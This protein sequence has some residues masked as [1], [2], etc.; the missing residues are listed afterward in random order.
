MF[1]LFGSN[2]LCHWKIKVITNYEVVRFR[3]VE[4]SRIRLSATCQEDYLDMRDGGCMSAWW[5]LH[6]DRLSLYS[7]NWQTDNNDLERI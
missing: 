3:I 6:I 1:N 4:K 5:L 2:I 7:R